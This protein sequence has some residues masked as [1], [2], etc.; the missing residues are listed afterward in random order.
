MPYTGGQPIMPPLAVP[1]QDVLDAQVFLGERC[2]YLGRGATCVVFTN[3]REVVRLATDTPGQTARFQVDAQIRQHLTRL[4]ARTPAPLRVGTLPSGR[5]F[6]LDSLARNPDG[7]P[8]PQGWREVGRTLKLLHALPH[9]GFGLLQDRSDEL[10]G[11][12]DTAPAGINTRLHEVWPF[13]R[14][15][16]EHQPLIWKAPELHPLIKRLESELWDLTNLPSSVCHTDLH[17]QQFHW[18]EN[19]ELETLLDFGEA[20]IGPEAWDWA[21]LAF[22]H[23]WEVPELAAGEIDRH[24]VLFG[25]LLAFH[26]AAKAVQQGQ[27]VRL[28]TAI[29]FA[30][31]C[32]KRL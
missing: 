20:S 23:G 14:D 8:G 31:G 3:G 10:R 19:G 1:P 29:R 5:A 26:R 28:Q 15:L 22:F 25:L 30:K 6:S 13:T 7:T 32:L 4:S 27:D 24:S 12:A 17:A 9:T 18:Q 21:S 2:R 11:Q 16:L